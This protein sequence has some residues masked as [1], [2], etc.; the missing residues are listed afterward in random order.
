MKLWQFLRWYPW[1]SRDEWIR[2]REGDWWPWSA[3]DW[4]K[5]WLGQWVLIDRADKPATTEGDIIALVRAFRRAVE[6]TPVGDPLDT[7]EWRAL[8]AAMNEID[9]KETPP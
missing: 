4:R 3:V 8:C 2:Y 1:R 9:R 7:A 6:S 5:N